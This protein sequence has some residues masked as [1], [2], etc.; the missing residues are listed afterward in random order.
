MVSGIGPASAVADLLRSIEDLG[1]LL[2]QS[3]AA[4]M[5][6]AEKLMKAGVQQTVQDASV[7]ARIDLTA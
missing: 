7:G 2:A 1:R 3:Q 5:N 4:E 6:M